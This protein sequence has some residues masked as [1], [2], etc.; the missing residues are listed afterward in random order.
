MRIWVDA[1]ACPRVIKEVIYTVAQRRQIA[2]TLVAN[3]SMHI[4]LNPLINLVKVSEGADVA[5]SYIVEQAKMGDLVITA[6]IP[7]AH[8]I[9]Q[10]TITAINPRGEIYTEENISERL[11]M[12]NFMQGLRDD[13]LITG[14]PAEFSAKDKERFTNALDRLLAKML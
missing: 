14:G 8:L 12:R 5:D 6:D 4:P 10:K 7:L 11:S 9:V 3:S 2:V 13:G 1:D